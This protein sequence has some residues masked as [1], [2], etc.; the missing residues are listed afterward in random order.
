MSNES[1]ESKTFAAALAAAQ[2]KMSNPIK[3]SVNPQYRSRY[4]DLASVRDAVV[5]ALASEGIGIVQEELSEARDGSVWCGVRTH[6]VHGDICVTYGPLWCPVVPVVSRDG[7]EQAITHAMGSVLTYLRRYALASIACVAADDDDD[8]NGAGSARQPAK[9]QPP[10]PDPLAQARAELMRATEAAGLA[11][12]AKAEDRERVC[13]D[14]LGIS[15]AAAWT[16][17]AALRKL[18]GALRGQS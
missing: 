6:L 7:K 15:P 4:A 9:R 11:G 1:N 16:D 2:A 8:G 5:P 10:R 18:A 14:V 17:A 12:D 13:W 3:S